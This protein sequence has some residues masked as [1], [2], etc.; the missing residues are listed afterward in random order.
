MGRLV[1][2]T[3]GTRSGKSAFAETRL[4]ELAPDQPWLYV[5][6]AEAFDEEMKERIARHRQRRGDRWRTVEA[7]R[8]PAD[9]LVDFAGGALVDCL[10]LWITNLLV[11]GHDDEPI[12]G[13]VELLVHTARRGPG[14]VV[15]VTNEVGSGIVPE[16]ALARRFRDLAGTCNQVVAR[17]ADEAWLVAAGLPLKLK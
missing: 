14:T 4:K 6:T 17:A 8:A 7:P 12:V 13:A 1:L 9:P 2:V 3:G 5:A 10:T 16:N 15:L 11:E